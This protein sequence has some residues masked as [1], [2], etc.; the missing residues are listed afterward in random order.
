MLFRSP[1]LIYG[2][3]VKPVNLGIRKTFSDIGKT[4]DDIFG[5]NSKIEGN[6]FLNDINRRISL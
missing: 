4:I 2:K 3:N 6:S 5:I 1:L